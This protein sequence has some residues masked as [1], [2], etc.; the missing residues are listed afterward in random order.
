RDT[1]LGGKLPLVFFDEFDSDRDG[2]ALGWLKNFLMPMQDGKFKDESGEHPLGRCILVFAGGTAATFGEF[3]NPSGENGGVNFK[4]VKGPDFVSRLRGTID[5]LGPNPKDD[6]DKN[7]IIRRALLL[8]S[9]VERNS[10]LKGNFHNGIV[11]VSD[12]IIRAMLHVPEFKHGARSMEA[13]LDMSRIDGNSWEPVS[14]PSRSQLALHVDA[15]AFIRLVL[16]E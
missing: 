6:A 9:L 1:I 4:N 15:D 8:R 7:F 12:K 13:I 3:N 16:G 5:V 14:L 2:N 10:K 11:P